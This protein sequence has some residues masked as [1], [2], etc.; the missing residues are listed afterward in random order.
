MGG[1]MQPGDAS[2][3]V[4]LWSSNGEAGGEQPRPGQGRRPGGGTGKEAGAVR[5]ELV[6]GVLLRERR[7]GLV[8]GAVHDLRQQPRGSP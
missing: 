6:L 7:H 5:T 3:R 2:G 1:A 8:A 4:A